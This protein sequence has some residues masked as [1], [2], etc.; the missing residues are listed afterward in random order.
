MKRGSLRLRLRGRASSRRRAADGIAATKELHA[1]S[2]V[3]LSTMLF[4]TTL[5]VAAGLG[6]VSASSIAPS[7]SIQ[8]QLDKLIFM[9]ALPELLPCVSKAWVLTNA[10]CVSVRHTGTTAR[11][12]RATSSC[13][14]R[15]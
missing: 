9:C 7:G 5:A 14:Y 13:T 15:R 2:Q 6:A 12:R 11:C 8:E 3:G 10:C 1:S 4:A